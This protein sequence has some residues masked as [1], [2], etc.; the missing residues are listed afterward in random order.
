VPSIR[1]RTS[2]DH[3]FCS[4][5]TSQRSHTLSCCAR[6]DFSEAISGCSKE[7]CY[8]L[9]VNTPHPSSARIRFDQ[10]EAD[11]QTRELYRAGR[12]V[13]VPNQS[14]VV[15]ATLL[16]RPGELVTREELRK[17]LWPKETYVEY[18][19]AL[20]ASV[21]R[22]REAL[23]DSADSP[24]FIETLPRRG[25]RF[26]GSIEPFVESSAIPSEQVAASASVPAKRRI[27]WIGIL[28]VAL[29]IGAVSWSFL[30]GRDAPQRAPRLTPLTTL[31]DRETAPAFSP[32]AHE[33]AFAWNGDSSGSGGFDL[34]VKSVESENTLRLTRTPAQQL[35]PAWSHDGRHIAFIRSAGADSGIFLV[36]ALGGDER[37][38]IGGEMP[39]GALTH[40][41]WSADDKELLYTGFGP[42]GGRS[43]FRL[44]LDS[45]QPQLVKLPVSCWDAGAGAYSPSGRE[46]AFVCTKS[47]AVYSIQTMSLEDAKPLKRLE[48]QGYPKGLTWSSDGKSV[49]FANDSGDGG[50]LWRMDEH[51][52]PARIPFGEEASEPVATASGNGIGYVRDRERIDIWRV[53]LKDASPERTATRLISSTR[54]QM[55]PRYSPD[56]QHIAFQ[57]NRS[58]TTE[59]W[60]ADADGKNAVRLSSFN[61]PLNGAPAW[62][63]DSKQL[64]F[65][66]RAPGVSALYVARID[67]RLPR[68]IKTE[69][70][71]LALPAW[72]DDCTSLVASDGNDHSYVVSLADGKVQRLTAQRSYYSSVS[73]ARVIFNVKSDSG[74]MLWS[75]LQD[76]TESALE[77]MPSLS[78]DDSWTTTERGI[79]FTRSSEDPRIVNFYD[80]ASRQ[81]RPVVKLG[82]A[83][84]A[85][86]GL[87]LSLSPDERYL[88]Y[89]QTEERQSDVMLLEM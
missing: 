56:G 48:V 74:V 60:V 13:R 69:V 21:N 32:S 20:N 19:Q 61:G 46:I 53:D 34:Y 71:N 25:Y 85:A 78:Y 7:I 29:V 51:G 76:G 63:S 17:A 73:G 36:P 47:V 59:I 43:L 81:I 30:G 65:D 22:L 87:G 28:G 45:L 50:S 49:I 58:G 16:S 84:T 79:Y 33:F 8:R 82:K 89:T 24:R 88:L 83:P 44:S 80:F 1:K 72:S 38:L 86:G 55:L 12:R 62:C 5:R 23:R 11:L 4:T 14:F 75:K 68:R 67:E 54:V 37:R 10:F 9:A 52:M 42:N 26:V 77:G 57:S 40:L 27:R 70:E 15:L 41:A 64:A 35:I 39:E 3:G 6:S 66:S 18:D 2:D 31:P